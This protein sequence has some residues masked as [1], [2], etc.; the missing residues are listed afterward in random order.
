VLMAGLC[1]TLFL[2]TTLLAHAYQV[3]PSEQETVVSQLARGIF[4]GRELPYYAVQAGTMLTLVLAAN[5]AYA[6]FPRLASIV[7]R[8]RFL[9]RQFMNQGDRLA[10]S[11]GIVALSG[12]AGL[13]IVI[14]RG[15]T[16]ALIP[17]YMIGVF[18]SFT[19]SQSGMVLKWK[20]EATR[21]WQGHA[22]FNAVGALL[23]AVVLVV[24]AVTKF[25]E[26]AW[27]IL[28][29]IPLLVLWA[30]AVHGHYERVATQLSLQDYTPE[31]LRRNTVV[32]PI[33]ACTGR[34]WRRCVMPPRSART[35]A[36]STWTSTPWPPSTPAASG[37]AGARACRWWCWSR[38]TARSWNP[39]STTSRG[40]TRSGRTTS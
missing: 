25:E 17:L 9:P 32:V 18:V 31:E 28:A 34:W 30:R 16:H 20:R 8:D 12:V 38:P 13:L 5:T 35:C 6:D 2:G 11:N 15:D 4:G 10:F 36:R 7:A 27:V 22:A 14:F 37:S 39:S 24:V 29:I 23:S 33:G 21:G 26:G 3:M 40:S 1:V 19:L